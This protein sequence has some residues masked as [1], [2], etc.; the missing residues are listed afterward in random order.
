[1][2]HPLTLDLPSEV[3]EPLARQAAEEGRP[4][5]TVAAEWLLS[6]MPRHERRSVLEFAG[7]LEADVSDLGARHDHYL[8]ADPSTSA[9]PARDA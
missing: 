7:S 8:N 3:Y 1:M 5:E 4:L 2:N 6:G 9:Q